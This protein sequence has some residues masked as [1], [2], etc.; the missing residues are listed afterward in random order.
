M[1]GGTEEGPRGP[2]GEDRGRASQ[3]YTVRYTAPWT[4]VTIYCVRLSTGRWS[5]LSTASHL[6][7]LL[8]G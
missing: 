7:L 6:I 2:A 8:S 4:L 5:S 3:L 1:L